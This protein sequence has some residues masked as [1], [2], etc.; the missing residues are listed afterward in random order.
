MGGVGLKSAIV[1]LLLLLLLLI[2]EYPTIFI[3]LVI[4]VGGVLFI[5]IKRAYDKVLKEERAISEAIEESSDIYKKIRSEIDIPVETR[6]VYY[7]GG[8]VGILEGSLQV[9]L[10]DGMLCFFPFVPVIDEPVDIKDK[11]Y[12]F[13]INIRDIECFCKRENR[14]R[15]TI[16]KYSNKGK[17]YLMEFSNKDYRIFKEVIPDKVFTPSISEEGI[18]EL[19]SSD[20]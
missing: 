9:W 15:D 3:P 19:A 16:L 17:D 5:I 13:K 18:G 1:I 14:G 2:V 8:D 4:L 7:K 10:K 6:I 11:V 12:L 20:R